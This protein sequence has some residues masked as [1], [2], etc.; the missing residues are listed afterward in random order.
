MSCPS[1]KV[2]YI[3]VRGRQTGTNTA[4]TGA[5][6]AAA[7]GWHNTSGRRDSGWV[8]ASWCAGTGP[9]CP[10]FFFLPIHG[11]CQDESPRPGGMTVTPPSLPPSNSALQ[12]ISTKNTPPPWQRRRLTPKKQSPLCHADVRLSFISFYS[13]CV[14]WGFGGGGLTG[15]VTRTRHNVTTTTTTWPAGLS[16][17]GH[18]DLDNWE[19][20]STLTQSHKLNSR[21]FWCWCTPVAGVWSRSSR[22]PLLF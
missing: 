14:C 21:H 2:I 4:L 20:A 9:L 7:A 17:G 22:S 5:A 12:H 15:L 19:P 16:T 6:R 13:R 10:P 8:P 18:L 1:I 3:L 11:M